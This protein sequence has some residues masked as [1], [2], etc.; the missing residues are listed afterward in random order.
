M[1][2]N[3][4][5]MREAKCKFT[6]YKV[7]HR[8]CWTSSRLN[9]T[10]LINSD[11][12]RRRQMD[13]FLHWCCPVLQLSPSNW[14][15]RTLPSLPRLCLRDR[16]WIHN[17]SNGEFPGIMVSTR[18]TLWKTSFLQQ[19]EG[20]HWQKSTNVGC[21]LDSYHIM[22]VLWT[23]SHDATCSSALLFVFIY[24]SMSLLLKMVNNEVRLTKWIV[25]LPHT[26]EKNNKNLN[27]KKM[28]YQ[29][30]TEV[31]QNPFKIW[32]RLEEAIP[33]NF[34]LFE[35]WNSLFL[36]VQSKKSK[37]LHQIW[38]RTEVKRP[39]SESTCCSVQ[40]FRK[41][42]EVMSDTARAIGGNTDSVAMDMMLFLR[43]PRWNPN[44]PGAF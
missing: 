22:A 29:T 13:A 18:I 26:K 35:H 5:Y 1:A 7:T 44:L 27:T 16:T 20:R 33:N 43:I 40:H 31:T 11:L 8:F 37:R 25:V 14:L 21:F 41:E 32:N 6:W 34:C 42:Q 24:L 23:L 19:D 3:G 12:C 36:C 9:R 38:F 4:K 2:D 10:G 30:N 28:D 17:S 39:S 15:W